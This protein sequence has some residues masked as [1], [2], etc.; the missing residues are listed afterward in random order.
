MSGLLAE[1]AESLSLPSP[2]EARAIRERAG[3]SQGRLGAE[4]GKSAMTVHRW[5]TGE[6]T[7]SGEARLAYARLL[8]QLDQVVRAT[9]EAA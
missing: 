6:H 9:Q 8:R 7:P 2:A 3:V 5:E 4:I 1:V